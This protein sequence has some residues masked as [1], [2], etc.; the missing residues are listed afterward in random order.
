MTQLERSHEVA[1]AGESEDGTVGEDNWK[2][3]DDLDRIG[4]RGAEDVGLM[5]ESSRE[6]GR[7]GGGAST[8]IDFMEFA[9]HRIENKV[10]AREE[11]G[12]MEDS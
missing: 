6:R 11:D 1:E 7:R 9:I 3:T 2:I 8:G 10:G 4:S 5:R 12:R